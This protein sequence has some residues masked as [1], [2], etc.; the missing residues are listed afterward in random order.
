MKRMQC[1][2]ICTVCSVLVLA[3]G[4]CDKAK[5]AEDAVQHGVDYTLCL[6]ASREIHAGELPNE[7]IE[8]PYGVGGGEGEPIVVVLN[9]L[10]I[11][12]EWSQSFGLPANEFIVPG[13]NEIEVRCKPS[14]T[15]FIKIAKCI[16]GEYV[17][18]PVSLELEPAAEEKV[19]RLKFREDCP[20][21]LKTLV[22]CEDI[23]SMDPVRVRE[24]VLSELRAIY[25]LMKNRDGAK[26]AA[27]V[28]AGYQ[29]WATV[30]YG[31][32]S[33][34]VQRVIST[35]EDFRCRQADSLVDVDWD[36]VKLII[37]SRGV[38]AYMGIW[39]EQGRPTSF[40]TVHQGESFRM[41]AM[42]LIRVSGKWVVWSAT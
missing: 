32:P 12:F 16:R 9:G 8:V 28:W 1:R 7:L 2:F 27:K 42:T 18:D 23:Q 38:L 4:G 17:S 3:L 24:E 37:G 5:P 20:Y 21:S 39:K 31:S 36:S 22:Q 34:D 25:D 40:A 33:Q 26:A 6:G 11:L 15:L 41:P 29:E 14:K 13:E 19:T 30:A 35:W 10:P